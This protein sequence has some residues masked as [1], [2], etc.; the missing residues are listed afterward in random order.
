MY[1]VCTACWGEGVVDNYVPPNSSSGT[2]KIVTEKCDTCGGT[3]ITPTGHF[4]VDE[5]G[6]M[7]PLK[8]EL[9]NFPESERGFI[10]SRTK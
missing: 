3:G 4:T 1:K 7:F 6:M 10:L 2:T 8:R 5:G 9:E